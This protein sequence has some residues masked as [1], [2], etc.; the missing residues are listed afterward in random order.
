MVTGGA[1]QENSRYFGISE[2]FARLLKV[3]THKGARRSSVYGCKGSSFNAIKLYTTVPV[4]V[5]DRH[6]AVNI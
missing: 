5:C 4:A 1:R 3:I 2:G 6:P